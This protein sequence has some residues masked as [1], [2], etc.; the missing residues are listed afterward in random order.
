MKQKM[1]FLPSHVCLPKTFLLIP[2][3]P[4]IKGTARF[5]CN[6]PR[7]HLAHLWNHSPAVSWELVGLSPLQLISSQ[8]LRPVETGPP[9]SVYSLAQ[10]TN[11][12]WDNTHPTLSVALPT[13]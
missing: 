1:I 7:G 3:I 10:G 2:W 6:E 8:I 13:K 5:S 11:F 4:T 12:S 9:F